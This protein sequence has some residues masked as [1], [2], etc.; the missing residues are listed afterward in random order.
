MTQDSR[1]SELAARFLVGSVKR[2]LP[3]P[4]LVGCLGSVSECWTTSQYASLMSLS[5]DT[6]RRQIF[7]EG[8]PA[9]KAG[10]Q[11]RLYP[12]E[13]AEWQRT[14]DEHEQQSR[15][16]TPSRNSGAVTGRTI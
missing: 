12:P 10:R 9:H 16:K 7:N 5:V 2:T 8:L 1:F 3:A 15:K 13:V 11:W 4:T 6:V 14:R